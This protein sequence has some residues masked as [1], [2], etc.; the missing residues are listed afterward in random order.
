MD[1]DT[2][3]ALAKAL[4][5]L[6]PQHRPKDY[7]RVIDLIERAIGDAIEEHRQDAPHVYADGRTY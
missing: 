5:E 4:A 7:L 3:E 2:R 6:V 1:N